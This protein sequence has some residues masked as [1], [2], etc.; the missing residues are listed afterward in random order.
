MDIPSYLKPIEQVLTGNTSFSINS[1]ITNPNQKNLRLM[2]VSTH[3]QQYTGYSKISHGILNEL[4][5]VPNIDLI[6]FGFQKHPQVSPDFRKYPS[7][8]DVIDAA[9]LENP[10]QQG[11]GFAHLM[12]CLLYTSPS[13][14][15]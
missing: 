10:L 4:S 12:D 1:T 3:I 7:G 6:H 13:P 14:R 11:F 9:S 8:V 15:D 5:K 2:L